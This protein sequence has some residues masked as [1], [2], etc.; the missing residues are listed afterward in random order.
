MSSIKTFVLKI[1][2]S[3][4]IFFVKWDKVRN[5]MQIILNSCK[6]LVTLKYSIFNKRKN[7]V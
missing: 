7:N 4:R 3:E 1:N 6:P 5:N 2:K